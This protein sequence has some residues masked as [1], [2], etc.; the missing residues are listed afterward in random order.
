MLFRIPLRMPFACHGGLSSDVLGAAAG[1]AHRMLFRIPLRMPF[2]CHLIACASCAR[3]C[4]Y[5]G[6][7]YGPYYDLYYGAC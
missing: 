3:Y 6:A 1:G 5:H 4:V 7:Y 2:A